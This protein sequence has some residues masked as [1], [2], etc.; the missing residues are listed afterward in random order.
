[1]EWNLFLL[2][3]CASKNCGIYRDYYCQGPILQ[4]IATWHLSVVSNAMLTGVDRSWNRRHLKVIFFNGVITVQRVK[5]H[6]NCSATYL[7][8]GYIFL[9]NHVL[10]II[11]PSVQC[12]IMCTPGSVTMLS[13]QKQK[14]LLYRQVC[15]RG[16]S[17]SICLSRKGVSLSGHLTKAVPL[18]P[19]P[20]QSVQHVLY[21][22]NLWSSLSFLHKYPNS[23]QRHFT[24]AGLGIISSR[25]FHSKI[26]VLFFLKI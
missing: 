14:S 13:K 8:A 19:G 3:V 11:V 18:K 4:S 22:H 1:M 5:E 17:R 10:P 12:P 7:T 9:P 16:R 26:Q 21:M 2:F 20:R 25:N 23:C 6:H 24:T 15:W